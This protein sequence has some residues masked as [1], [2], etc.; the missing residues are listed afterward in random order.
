V[1]ALA[2]AWTP[3]SE[4]SRFIGSVWSGAFAG[5]VIALPASG[6]LIAEAGWPSVFYVFGGAGVVWAAAWAAL[7]ASS[8]E[9]AAGI[10][11]A[12]LAHI[13]ATRGSEDAARRRARLPWRAIFSSPAVWA[14]A[15]QHATHNYMF[16]MLLTW[17]PNYLN[18]QLG[19]D[20]EN[21][22]VLA[23]VPY[24]ACFLA[25]N[26]AGVLADAALAR[27]AT[28]RSVR[29]ASQFAA[30]VVPAATLLAVGFITDVPA[31][32]TLLTLSVGF[33]GFQGSGFAVNHLD[34]APHIAGVLMGVGNTLATVSGIIAPIIVGALVAKPHDDAAHWRIAFALAAGIA[35]AG[36]LVFAACARGERQPELDFVLGEEDEEGAAAKLV[37]RGGAD[38]GYAVLEARE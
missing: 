2:S 24:M 10:D 37:P 25:S 13:A 27:G 26:A 18:Q 33:G 8:P 4:R 36:F 34:I 6:V 23:V 19:F 14:I 3:A 20:V 21:S 11:P 17:L 1:H 38:D 32:L 28:P 31:V 29:V 9:Q 5:T 7:G 12:E 35:V 22:G 16:Y 30:E 15:I